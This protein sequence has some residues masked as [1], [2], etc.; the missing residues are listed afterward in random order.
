MGKC[1]QSGGAIIYKDNND[2]SYNCPG[3]GEGEDENGKICKT[4]PIS[5]E[6]LD[7]D[8]ISVD[9]AA[10]CFSRNILCQWL[11][12]GSR[13]CPLDRQIFPENKINEWC[14]NSF[15]FPPPHQ[16]HFVARAR[17]RRPLTLME[18]IRADLDQQYNRRILF[19][20][21]AAA[22]TIGTLVTAGPYPAATIFGVMAG[23]YERNV[24][25]LEDELA[26]HRQRREYLYRGLAAA[27]LND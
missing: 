3:A 8:N 10:H 15:Y 11:G 1:K 5:M 22:I 18:A 6:C 25:M 26:E 14:A 24:T 19:Y 12:R 7:D 9:P 17:R 21:A 4:D 2:P 16:R 27:D 13:T 23:L 20:T